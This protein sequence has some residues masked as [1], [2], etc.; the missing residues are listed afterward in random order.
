[1]VNGQPLV[2][3]DFGGIDPSICFDGDEAYYCTN[4]FT[5]GHEAI[6]L[7]EISTQY[8]GVRKERTLVKSGTGQAAVGWKAR[9]STTLETIIRSL[10]QRA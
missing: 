4:D 10:R 1:M 9:M 7:A 8:T 6:V 3:T 5:N 2:W